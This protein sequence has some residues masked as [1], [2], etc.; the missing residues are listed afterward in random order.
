M[1]P[2]AR[3]AAAITILDQI[4][5]GMVAEQA[6]TS[7]ARASRFAGSKDR[8][9]VRDHV[10]DVLR[11]RR[12]LGDGAGRSLMIRL[13]QRDGEPVETYF[14]GVG[15][16][17]APL[18]EAE[19]VVLSQPLTLGD[20][21]ACDLPD[22]LWPIWQ[23][24]L[25]DAA[26]PAAVA[27]QARADVFL[28]VNRRRGSVTA[29]IAALAEDQIVAVQH[30]TIEGCLRVTTNARRI[31][32]AA[33]YRD[34]L[35]ELQDAASQFAVAAVSVKKG[36]RVLDYCAGGGGKAL[37]FADRYAA[38]VFAHDVAP[39]RM[40][41]IPAR[42]ARAKVGITLIQ[43]ADLANSG[44]FDL[45]FCDAPCSGSGTWR[46]APD[47]KWR[48]VQTRL[49]ALTN[50]Q[51]E[52]IASAAVQVAPGGTLVYATCSVLKPENDGIIA[53]FLSTYP[54]W[55]INLR[56][57]LLPGLDGDGFFLCGLTRR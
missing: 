43:N 37:A 55:V 46:R 48:L 52:V 53:Q 30:D 27:Q 16:A 18:T 2:G 33:A 57:Q 14:D 20:A 12:S 13:L 26:M 40:Q 15:H 50:L 42:A 4:K 21:A 49:D 28:R 8:A 34:G 38:Q 10:F 9:A 44:L 5:A 25:G 29:A 51:Q 23:D 11:A 32:S 36:A 56:H 39:Q 31:K 22:W 3:V 24:S 47:A 41:D 17:P 7:W 35:V 19:Q 6:L 45:V 1:T 54:E